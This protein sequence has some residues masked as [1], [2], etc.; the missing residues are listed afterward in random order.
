MPFG[1][2][3]EINKPGHSDLNSTLSCRERFILKLPDAG[4]HIDQTVSS[5]CSSPVFSKPAD[6]MAV[7]GFGNANKVV[8]QS[9]SQRQHVFVYQPWNAFLEKGK[10]EK[11]ATIPR[12]LSRE[13]IKP[14]TLPT[15]GVLMVCNSKC[16]ANLRP[17][18]EPSLL[19]SHPSPPSVPRP[20]MGSPDSATE[21]A[22]N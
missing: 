6:W 17:P 5:S 19:P 7:R 10:G 3:E 8:S 1:Q 9:T 14:D 15:T 18:L 16:D 12:N 4:K 2:R 22:A 21:H 13:I 20:T 11:T